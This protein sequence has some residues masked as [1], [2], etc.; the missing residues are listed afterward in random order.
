LQSGLT[1]GGLLCALRSSIRS[2]P[3]RDDDLQYIVRLV[4]QVLRVSLD[5]VRL[6]KSLLAAF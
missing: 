5:S 3:N 6:V 4:G 2:D 1:T